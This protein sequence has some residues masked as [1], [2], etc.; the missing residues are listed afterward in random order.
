[1]FQN[2]SMTPPALLTCSLQ[3][4]VWGQR[5]A[6]H[7]GPGEGKKLGSELSFMFFYFTFFKRNVLF[8]DVNLCLINQEN[9]FILDKTDSF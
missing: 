2:R 3:D 7:P 9:I 8:W 1:M 4:G 6:G 5:A